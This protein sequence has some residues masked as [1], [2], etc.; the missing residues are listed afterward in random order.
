MIFLCTLPCEVSLGLRPAY[1]CGAPRGRTCTHVSATTIIEGPR[2][3]VTI[4]EHFTF[5]SSNVVY[6][7]SCYH[8]PALYTGETGR[9]LRERKGEHLR[10]VMRNP[11]GFPIA[12]RFNTPGHQI[13]DMEVRCIKQCRETNNVRSL[14]EMRLIFYLGTLTPYEL[15]V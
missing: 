6:C 5:I 13:H 8:C 10:T 3:N 7:I 1:P 2:H 4:R 14:D 12:E 15:N 9:M 11:P